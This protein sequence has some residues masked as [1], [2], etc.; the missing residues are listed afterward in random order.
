MSLRAMHTP[1]C[2]SKWKFRPPSV[3]EEA[4]S[5]WFRFGSARAGRQYRPLGTVA[6]SRLGAD[7]KPLRVKGERFG[8]APSIP[9][10]TACARNCVSV[11]YAGAAESSPVS[12]TFP[13]SL[14]RGH[15]S[16]R[17]TA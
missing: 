17:L 7:P 14:L 13:S 16:K 12:G 9:G 6:T 5:L 3:F 4:P 1:P 11:G 15:G 10:T 8:A 2:R